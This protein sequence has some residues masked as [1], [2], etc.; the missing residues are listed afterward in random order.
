MNKQIGEVNKLGQGLI[1][2]ATAFVSTN[3]VEEQ[4]EK[5]NS[6]WSK[7]Q[8]S[9]SVEF[10]LFFFILWNRKISTF[11]VTS[12]ISLNLKAGKRLSLFHSLIALLNSLSVEKFL[13]KY[14]QAFDISMLLHLLYSRYL[15]PCNICFL[16]WNLH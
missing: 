2:S 14:S 3:D 15:A 1:Q 4:L 11:I 10:S 12:A 13:A 8:E 6:L 7:L 16:R 5:L 9:V